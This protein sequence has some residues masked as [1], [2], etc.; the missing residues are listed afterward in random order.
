MKKIDL[1]QSGAIGGLLHRI[2]K[3]WALLT[4]GTTERSNSMTVG[5][6]NFGI[7]WKRPMAT[8]YV[9][10]ERYTYEFVEAEDYFSLAFFG[11]EHRESLTFCGVKSG[12]DYDKAAE[13]GFTV[14]AGEA[15]GVYYAEADLV[16]ICKKHYRAPLEL[17]K[18][19]DIDPTLYYSEKHGGVHMMYFG[20]IV[21]VLTKEG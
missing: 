16:V 18:M 21:E 14:R 12:R 1:S 3:E 19:I 8:I 6:C 15:G 20:E 11:P 13:C 4:A 2:D 7:L 17:D 10:P 9:R 5:W